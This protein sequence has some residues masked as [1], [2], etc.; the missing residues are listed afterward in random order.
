MRISMWGVRCEASSMHGT[1]N[2][3]QLNRITS[4]TTETARSSTLTIIRG[5]EETAVADLEGF[6]LNVPVVNV[7]PLLA[8]RLRILSDPL[9]H[10]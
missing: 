7:P 9:A 4:I 6:P 8:L 1:F 3:V 10:F 5:I 2:G